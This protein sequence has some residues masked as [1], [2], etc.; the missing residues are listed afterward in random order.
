MRGNDTAAQNAYFEEKA[1]AVL[2]SLKG[3]TP[4]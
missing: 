1:R 3:G 2:Q 4:R